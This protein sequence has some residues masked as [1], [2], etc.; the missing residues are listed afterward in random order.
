M[1]DLYGNPG[2]NNAIDEY[3]GF[4]GNIGTGSDPVRNG[5]FHVFLSSFSGGTLGAGVVSFVAAL[6]QEVQFMRRKDI[7][8]S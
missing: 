6:E 1:T 3:T 8:L 5:F 4:T 2:I 7:A